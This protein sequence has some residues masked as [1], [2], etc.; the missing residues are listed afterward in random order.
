MGDN[1]RNFNKP[2]KYFLKVT[3]LLAE[4]TDRVMIVYSYINQHLLLNIFLGMLALFISFSVA[5]LLMLNY[6]SFDAVL[7]IYKEYDYVVNNYKALLFLL[8]LIYPLKVHLLVYSIFR[9]HPV[10]FT[11]C[12]LCWGVV[13]FY[14]FKSISIYSFEKSDIVMGL[15]FPQSILKSIKDAQSLIG[16]IISNPTSILTIIL[17]PYFWVLWV[18]RHNDKE[19][20]KSREQQLDEYNEFNRILEMLGS[21]SDSLLATGIYKLDEFLGR[22][23]P[24]KLSSDN[25]FQY[26]KKKKFEFYCEQAICALINAKEIIIENENGEECGAEYE[27]QKGVRVKRI[28][29]VAFL[30][31]LELQRKFIII[32]KHTAKYIIKIE[33]IKWDDLCSFQNNLGSKNLVNK[34]LYNCELCL[35]DLNNMSKWYHF[36]YD[37]TWKV[38]FNN[39][40]IV[41]SHHGA[42]KEVMDLLKDEKLAKDCKFILNSNL[43]ESHEAFIM[44]LK[45]NKTLEII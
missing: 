16:I 26:K 9:K 4:L 2:E 40:R 27:K 36:Y 12:G 8:L 1:S 31:V 45:K 37:D 29:S 13:I 39:C 3:N 5:C 15:D 21:N 17:A 43:S 32:T 42:N 34:I 28:R 44:N 11:F 18:W 35:E 10:I 23:E 33:D 38:S 24:R 41:N 30:A 7:F 20:A 25:W 14:I 6:E 22:F 19:N